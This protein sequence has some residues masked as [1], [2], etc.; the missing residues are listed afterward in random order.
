MHSDFG[1][2]VV[3]PSHVHMQSYTWI[4]VNKTAHVKQSPSKA[5]MHFL[6][7]WGNC[8][9]AAAQQGWCNS[10][11]N[12]AAPGHGTINTSWSKPPRIMKL[13]H[14]QTHWYFWHRG[15]VWSS[16]EC[17]VM[18]QTVGIMEWDRLSP[19]C[20]VCLCSC[21]S[22]CTETLPI[23]QILI[24]LYIPPAK[25]AWHL[26]E[27]SAVLAIKSVI[28]LFLS[29]MFIYRFIS[30]RDQSKTMQWME[31]ASMSD[32]WGIPAPCHVLMLFAL[33][34][35]GWAAGLSILV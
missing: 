13:S 34:C 22:I 28:H 20:E 14:F 26:W 17:L 23:L 5:G 8:Q 35:A 1:S 25:C 4:R 29:R 11:L 16:S 6:A 7:A 33:L 27:G 31:R 9:G 24:V 32:R 15:G 12:T 30:M 10:D 19:A 18:F 2:V 3:A 21:W